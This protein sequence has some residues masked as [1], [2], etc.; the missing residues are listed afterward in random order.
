M[1]E[2]DLLILRIKFNWTELKS[3]ISIHDFINF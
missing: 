1:N 3:T 2:F